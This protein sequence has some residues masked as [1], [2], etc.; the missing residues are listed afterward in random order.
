MAKQKKAVLTQPIYTPPAMKEESL[1]DFF[2]GQA[3]SGLI[4]NDQMRSLHS[5]EELAK[6]AYESADVLIKKRESL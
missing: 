1:R 6:I 5:I 4:A 2:A 3:F